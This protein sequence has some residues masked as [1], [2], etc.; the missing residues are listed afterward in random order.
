MR[1]LE[2][3]HEVTYPKTAAQ[4]SEQLQAI[5]AAA[6]TC[7]QSEPRGDTEAFVRRL[8]TRG[9]DAM[10]EFGS[11]TV[12]FTTDR[13]VSH[14]IVRHRLFSFAQESTRYCRYQNEICVI[15]PSTWDLWSVR[16]RATWTDA[17]LDCERAYIT[18]LEQGCSPQQAR[19]VLPNS[20][21][22]TIIVNGNFREWRHFFALRDDEA[23]H[24]DMRAL[25]APL[26]EEVQ[27]LCPT[28]FL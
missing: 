26:H 17:M 12:R 28:I 24:P 6:R 11:M 4:W 3:A 15:S 10:L 1:L 13:G 22:T 19:A 18:M 9:H 25:V 27:Q 20:L 14:E 5:E 7:Y 2:Q 16:A 23:A 21:K 8:I